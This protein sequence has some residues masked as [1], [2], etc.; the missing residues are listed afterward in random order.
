MGRYQEGLLGHFSGK[1]GP[2]I[3]SSWKGVGYMRGKGKLVK[4]RVVS[5]KIANHR[6]KFRFAGNFIKAL[7]DL[8]SITF[9]QASSKISAP[10]N[11]LAGVMQQALR[12]EVPDLS[13]DYSLAKVA[14]GP[15]SAASNSSM[16][17][18][19][20]PGVITFVWDDNTGS[21]LFDQSKERRES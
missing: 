20:Q 3:G 21:L 10:N 7:G 2:V 9:P 5:D 15:L 17:T 12:G 16:A 13:I 6:E 19:S 18:S 8:L 1:V 14:D 4:R 11:A